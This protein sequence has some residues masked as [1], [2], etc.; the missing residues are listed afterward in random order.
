MCALCGELAKARNLDTTLNILAK[1]ITEIMDV[2]GATIR[3]LDEKNQTLEIVA[4]Y[5]LS[6]KYLKERP[7][8]PEET[9]C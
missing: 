7:C 5:G 1:N 3:L 6:K 2:K 4:A 9:P 8:Y